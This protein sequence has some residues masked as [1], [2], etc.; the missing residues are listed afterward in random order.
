MIRSPRSRLTARA[1]IV[2]VVAGSAV[3]TPV[4]MAQG[5][6]R[7][8]FATLSAGVPGPAGPSRMAAAAVTGP[9]VPPPGGEIVEAPFPLSHLGVRWQGSEEA[10]VDVRV[11]E[12]DGP[13]GPWRRMAHDHDLDDGSRPETGP[14]L[15]ELIRA[16]GATRIQTRAGGGAARV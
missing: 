5:A 7:T 2:A 16:D 15:S 14:H 8:R 13:F 11:A 3:F 9:T 12:A 1:L 4:H 6:P 10:V